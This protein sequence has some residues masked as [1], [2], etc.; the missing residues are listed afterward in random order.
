MELI[1][2]LLERALWECYERGVIDWHG[3][4]LPA[5]GEVFGECEIGTVHGCNVYVSMLGVVCLIDLDTM[6]CWHSSK[7]EEVEREYV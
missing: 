5:P 1:A 4:D 2:Q 7:I 6:E 3:D